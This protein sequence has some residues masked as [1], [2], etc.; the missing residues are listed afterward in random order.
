MYKIKIDLYICIITIILLNSKIKISN[1]AKI[2]TSF[3]ICIIF[4]YNDNLGL[5]GF[6]SLRGLTY[7]SIGFLILFVISLPISGIAFL[8]ERKKI[9]KNQKANWFIGN[10]IDAIFLLSI[11][12]IIFGLL[13]SLKKVFM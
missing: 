10:T 8:I 6:V 5:A 9:E 4:S 13:P 7:G 12:S 1:K 2:I 3:L 11:V